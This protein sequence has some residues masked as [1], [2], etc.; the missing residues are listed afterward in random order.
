MNK[1]KLYSDGFTLVELLIVI[2]IIGVL[3]GISIVAYNGIADRAREASLKQ[4]ISQTEKEIMV[5]ATQ[6]EEPIDIG[7]TMV[8]Y[9]DSIGVTKLIK[10]ITG[11]TDITMYIVFK[12]ERITDDY[13]TITYLM[14][15]TS[16]SR[17]RWQSGPANSSSINVRIDTPSQANAT[18]YMSNSRIPGKTIV[19][20]VQ[21][22]DDVRTQSIGF[23]GA[24]TIQTRVLE[25]GANWNFDSIGIGNN[26]VKGLAKVS[27]VFNTTHDQSTRQ[28][29]I[30]WLAEKYDVTL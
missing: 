1:R 29:I 28:Q 18:T 20:W 17:F 24:A 10:P 15:E 3:A 2:V 23:N 7:G 9:T 30:N 8:G 16:S 22:S 21:T 5:Y 4:T 14:P 11:A 12:A 6:N 13:Y 27:L 26:S 25:P 19:G